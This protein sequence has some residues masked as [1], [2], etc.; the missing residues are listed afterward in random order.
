MERIQ[1]T[2]DPFGGRFLVHGAPAMEVLEGAW[3][4]AL[5]IIRFPTMDRARAWYDSDAYQRLVPLPTRHVPGDV[6]LVDGV[7]PDCDPSA[8][9]ALL[10]AAR[11]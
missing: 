4:T 2:L 5:L 11:P 7:G 10:R 6:L 3:T 9:A 1:A 8:T